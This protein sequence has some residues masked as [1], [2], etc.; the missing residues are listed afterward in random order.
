MSESTQNLNDEILKPKSNGIEALK[1]LPNG[2]PD[3]S[4]AT[5]KGGSIVLPIV[6]SIIPLLIGT[7][8]ALAVYFLGSKD[9]YV[10]RIDDLI[11]NDLHWV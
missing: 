10:S 9:K 3:M 6:L 2:M 1:A 5:D 4:E 8:I 11:T 7:G